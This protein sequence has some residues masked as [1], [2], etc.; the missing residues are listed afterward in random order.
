M[1][2]RWMMKTRIDFVSNSSSCSFIVIADNGK[3]CDVSDVKMHSE[4]EFLYSIPNKDG[5]LKFGWQDEMYNSI[6][7]KLNWCGII[8][9]DLYSACRNADF[10]AALENKKSTE[11]NEHYETWRNNFIK[12]K[13]MLEKVCK[14]RLGFGVYLDLNW[15]KLYGADHE[16]SWQAF[17]EPFDC[18]IDHQSNIFEEPA[19]G[20]MFESED[21][22]YNFLA[23]EGSYIQCGNDNG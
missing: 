9:L 21:T 8:L 10:R 5:C 4:R 19:N 13:K 23:Y 2:W 6:E 12:W 17:V 16:D 3:H 20:K 11:L 7:D 15:L 22:L 14:E 1:I 18:Y